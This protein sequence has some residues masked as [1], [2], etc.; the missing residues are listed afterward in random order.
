MLDGGTVSSMTDQIRHPEFSGPLLALISFGAY[1]ASFR[2]NGLISPWT[3]YA[4]GVSLVFLPAGVKLVALLVAGG[5]G[6]LGLAS[7]ALL[8]ATD[9]WTQSGIGELAG[10]IAVWL[11]VPY[12]VVELMLRVLDVDRDLGNLRFWPLL[13]IVATATAAGS[14]AS[15]AYAVAFHGRQ[16][17][18]YLGAALAM[19]LGDVVGAGLVVI[20]AVAALQLPRWLRRRS[21]D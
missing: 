17:T 6:L 11:G 8:M 21:G 5:W 15:S 19:L 1:W 14:F 7:A 9:V 16:E 10:N 13:L 2:L 20:L 12:L 18:D 3:E 4:P